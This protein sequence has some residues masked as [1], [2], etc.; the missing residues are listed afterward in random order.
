[1]NADELAAI[2]RR[3][4]A[5]TP[6]PWRGAGV[7]PHHD[8]AESGG[9]R[10]VGFR[11]SRRRHSRHQLPDVHI[12]GQSIDGRMGHSRGRT[13]THLTK[14]LLHLAVTG[15]GTNTTVQGTNTWLDADPA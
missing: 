8:I 1:M 6:G 11:W 3:L 13:R 9:G 4:D 2:R 14:H 12:I 10:C 7:D 5:A 15:S